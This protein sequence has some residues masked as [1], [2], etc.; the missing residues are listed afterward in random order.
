MRIGK[1]SPYLL[2]GLA[3]EL[4]AA[5]AL[6]GTGGGTA[7]QDIIFGYEAGGGAF[8]EVRGNTDGSAL[9]LDVFIRVNWITYQ[10]SSNGETRAAWCQ[11]RNRLKRLDF[12]APD[13]PTI[14][15]CWPA[16]I[17]RLKSE[18]TA[19]PATRVLTP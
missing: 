8:A 6:A 2:V 15:T 7:S 4:L 3:V 10:N 9:P 18:R 11:P 1:L 17:S 13:G 12:P 19:W 5:A 16:S 14:A